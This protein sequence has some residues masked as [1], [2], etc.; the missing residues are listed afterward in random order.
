VLAAIKN[1]AYW[2]FQQSLTGT[3]GPRSVHPLMPLFTSPASRLAVL[4]LLQTERSPIRTALK[5][6]LD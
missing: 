3:A 4:A 6:A 1:K 5:A 2:C